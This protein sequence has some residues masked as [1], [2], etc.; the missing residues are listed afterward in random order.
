M[1]E[2]R[3]VTMIT[4]TFKTNVLAVLVMA[5]VCS[6]SY[7]ASTA[8]VGTAEL[9]WALCPDDGNAQSI[10]TALGVNNAVKS[11]A[12]TH[13][14]DSPSLFFKKNGYVIRTRKVT[15]A[16]DETVVKFSY[17]VNLPVP[18][19]LNGKP[20]GCEVDYYKGDQ[21]IGCKIA[22]DK[23]ED[24]HE[25]IKSVLNEPLPT[26]ITV[27]PGITDDTFDF[28]LA[29]QNNNEQA[30]NIEEMK[31]ESSNLK[32]EGTIFH[33]FE[34]STRV[35]YTS[36]SQAAK[37]YDSWNTYFTEK[38]AGKGVKFCDKQSGNTQK[39]FDA[40]QKIFEANSSQAH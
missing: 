1:L 23:V 3:R 32:Q 16:A 34:I 11:T 24:G 36:M 14:S 27:T 39:I 19:S 9:Q 5:S 10:L 35:H 21:K 25:V 26:D 28:K 38:F 30:F 7:A 29:D 12:Q 8:V 37:I 17:P 18:G 4:Q 13:Y 40:Y 22:I 33:S 2:Y 6:Y 20:I 31:L 15:G